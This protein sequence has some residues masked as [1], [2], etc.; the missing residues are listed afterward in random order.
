M[1][2]IFL[3]IGIQLYPVCLWGD[4]TVSPVNICV[5]THFCLLLHTCSQTS[6]AKS[7]ATL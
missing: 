2:H 4:Q 3:Y 1:Q 5:S 6:I 7:I